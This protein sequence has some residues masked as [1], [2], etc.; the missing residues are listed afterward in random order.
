L[1]RLC[2]RSRFAPRA[3]RAAGARHEDPVED[4]P[5]LRP[6]EGGADCA[7]PPPQR[8]ARYR[9]PIRP[10][11]P[12]IDRWAVIVTV[13]SGSRR[14][15]LDGSGVNGL[16]PGPL[17]LLGRLSPGRPGACRRSHAS[18]SPSIGVTGC[19]SPVSGAAPVLLSSTHTVGTTAKSLSST[20]SRLRT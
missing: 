2:A 3:R 19:A 17:R 7:E 8:Q 20:A 15:G 12:H 13:V 14:E 4:M 18:P 11:P 16:T 5:W 9:V 6:G 10:A 1:L